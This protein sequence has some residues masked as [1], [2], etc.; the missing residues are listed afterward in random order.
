MFRPGLAN[1]AKATYRKSAPSSPKRSPPLGLAPLSRGLL[2]G[3]AFAMSPRSTPAGQQGP[4]TRVRGCAENGQRDGP[5]AWNPAVQRERV[6]RRERSLAAQM[7][8]YTCVCVCVC[9]RVHGGVRCGCGVPRLG[10]RRP[11][12]VVAKQVVRI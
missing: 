4:G 1:T 5:D 6:G 9:V 11:T 7:L 2:A 3:A 12:V 10:W 8:V